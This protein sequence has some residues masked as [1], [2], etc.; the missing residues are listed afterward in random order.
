M[1]EYKI[2]VG[3]SVDNLE[4]KVQAFLRDGWT[5]IGGIAVGDMKLAQAVIRHYEF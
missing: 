2:V 1:I 3:Y 5:P 4:E